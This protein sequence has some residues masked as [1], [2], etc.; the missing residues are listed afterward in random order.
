MFRG[1]KDSASIIVVANMSLSLAFW[2]NARFSDV[3]VSV[4][5]LAALQGASLDLS[6]PIKTYEFLTLVPGLAQSS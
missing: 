4:S 2:S 5:S 6:E 3:N 1:I